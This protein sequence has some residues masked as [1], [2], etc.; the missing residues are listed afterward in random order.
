[1]SR[2]TGLS[3]LT[4]ANWGLY[5]LGGF[6][7]RLLRILLALPLLIAL[8]GARAQQA[9]RPAS[10][11]DSCSVSSDRRWTP[12]EKFV[13]ERV[14]VGEAAD[15]NATRGYGGKL[16]PLKPAGWP[17]SRVLRPAFLQMILLK[18]PYRR[19][20]TRYG[21]WII[22]AHFTE[23]VD[24]EN[25][26]LEHPLILEKSLIEQGVNLRRARSKFWIG[27]PSSKVAV[28][29]NMY[30]LQLEADLLMLNGEF[31][32]V[33][34][35][36]AHVS[37]LSL[38]GSKVTGER[39]DMNG[40]HADQ[41]L[42][43]AETELA[44]SSYVDLIGAHV[45]GQL[46]LNQ[47]KVS[48]ALYMNS[49]RVEQSL[50]M[51]NAEFAD[52]NLMYAHVGSLELYGPKV[53]GTLYMNG[54]QVDRDL[55]MDNAEFARVD[56]IGAHV[57]GKLSLN[58]SKVTGTLYMN[59][60]QVDRNLVMQGRFA[61]VELNGA[62]M[63]SLDLNGSKVTGGLEMSGLQADGG[64]FMRDKAEFAKVDLLGARVS[65][66]L[67]LSGSRVTGTLNMT[68]LQVD[69]LFMSDNAE[70]ADVNLNLAHV[71]GQL[72][73][74]GSKVTGKL[75]LSNTEIGALY[76]DSAQWS[77]GGSL[78]LR[79]AKV[80]SIPALADAWAPNLDL[81]RLTYR[82]VRAT[83]KYEDWLGRFDH[84]AP[85]PYD[86][87]A[88]VVQSQGDSALATQIRYSGRERQ[89]SEAG[90]GTWVWLTALKLLIGY[91]Y[92]PYYAMYWVI[93]LVLAGAGV[94]RVSGEGRRNGMPYGLAYSFDKLLPIIQLRKRHS[95][96]DVQGWP[97]YY[98]Y[99]QKI[100]GWV[101][102]SFLIAGLAGLTNKV[103]RVTARGRSSSE[104]FILSEVRSSTQPRRGALR[105]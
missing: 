24:L 15:F 7:M 27:F 26:E 33:Y 61:D 104:A 59:G 82:S 43:M 45:G 6:V 22:G 12:Q 40:L 41:G 90:D 19:A 9:A 38:K 51:D 50:V 57:G 35:H 30:E 67:S 77:Y 69:D 54:L 97:R 47:S 2:Q 42:S 21:V 83:D 62:H 37:T 28:G 105:F 13:W 16:D 48:G 102:G 36:G 63:R 84:Y 81:D 88:S 86:Q 89:R 101:L 94:L 52:V 72:N 100:M 74:K 96:I 1:M 79:D 4:G 39:L 8:P 55:V 76:L 23:L 31:T 92:Y 46:N 53:T 73:L 91:G 87:L 93:G 49:L 75:D 20:L 58:E 25:A 103:R 32:D 3:R 85:Q 64:L 66:R 99:G 17:K 70:F 68:G 11:D 95:D 56:L 10:L 5:E 14:C 29:F 80:G 65:I 98:F 34:L 71:G 60:L 44:I 78:I 18:D